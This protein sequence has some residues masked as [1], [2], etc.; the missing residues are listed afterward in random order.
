VEGE[1]MFSLHCN[2]DK[3]HRINLT[4]IGLLLCIASA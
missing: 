2:I 4:V 3:T 1:G